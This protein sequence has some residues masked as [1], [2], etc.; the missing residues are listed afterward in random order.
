MKDTIFEFSPF[1]NYLFHALK[2]VDL[3]FPA[4][5]NVKKYKTLLPSLG[6]CVTPSVWGEANSLQQM[7][8]GG[9]GI[10]NGTL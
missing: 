2:Y 1:P 3:N 8:W 5:A 9:G 10:K 6:A 7:R 4:I